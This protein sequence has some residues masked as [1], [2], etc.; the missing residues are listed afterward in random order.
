V[1]GTSIT[2]GDHFP[3][4]QNSTDPT[5]MVLLFA[6]LLVPMI[7]GST[8]KKDLIVREVLDR[9]GGQSVED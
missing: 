3:R 8:R 2:L 5:G 1:L 4:Y 7:A 6:C 9:E